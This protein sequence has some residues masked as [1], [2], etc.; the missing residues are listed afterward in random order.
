MKLSNK[1]LIMTVVVG[2]IAGLSVQPGH[3]ADGTTGTLTPSVDQY[4]A[5]SALTLTMEGLTGG[6][7]YA[8][9]FTANIWSGDDTN[10]QYTFTTG[11]TQ[12]KK[13]MTLENLALPSSGRKFTII[14]VYQSAG[15][16]IDRVELVA[17]SVSDGL[18]TSF[19]LNLAIPVIIFFVV[20]GIV[21]RFDIV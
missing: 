16:E 5:N 8:L 21:K 6:A 1:I 17:R 14:L 15:T 13:I 11:Q 9:N 12:T 18:P 4:Y 3:A 7:D 19:I 10:N 20:L 2:L